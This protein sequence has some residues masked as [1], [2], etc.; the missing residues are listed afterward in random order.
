[1][2]QFDISQPEKALIRSELKFTVDFEMVCSSIDFFDRRTGR[3]SFNIGS[4]LQF[5]ETV[6]NDLSGYLKWSD[7]QKETDKNLLEKRISGSRLN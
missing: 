2:H 3:L 1:M 5:K 6:I 4:V 7:E